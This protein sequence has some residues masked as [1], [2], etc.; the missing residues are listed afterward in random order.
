MLALHGQSAAL[1]LTVP[2]VGMAD[3]PT[4]GYY[5][6]AGDGGVFAFGAAF[7]GST[8]CLALDQPITDVVGM[9]AS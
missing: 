2:V 7:H 3:A 1:R 6:V 9:A 4:G 5:E 8:G